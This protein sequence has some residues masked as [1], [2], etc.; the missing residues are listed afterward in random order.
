[1]MMTKLNMNKTACVC[2]SAISH[3]TVSVSVQRTRVWGVGPLCTRGRGKAM[4]TAREKR[5][6]VE[7]VAKRLTG[8]AEKACQNAEAEASVT[9]DSL[10]GFTLKQFEARIDSALLLARREDIPIKAPPREIWRRR[11]GR[12]GGFAGMLSFPS[13]VVCSSESTHVSPAITRNLQEERARR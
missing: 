2:S 3:V 12:G 6:K 5:L 1:M 11:R 8:R 10:Q 9:P 7:G 4:T 13:S